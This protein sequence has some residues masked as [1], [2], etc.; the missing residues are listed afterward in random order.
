MQEYK[1]MRIT[2]LIIFSLLFTGNTCF[3]QINICKD[4]I[5]LQAQNE[6]NGKWEVVSGSGTFTSSATAKTIVKD[7][8]IGENVFQWSYGSRYY[9]KTE[10][11]KIIRHQ[12]YANKQYLC[13]GKLSLKAHS[14]NDKEH[15][16]EWTIVDGDATLDELLTNHTVALLKPGKNTF[17]W[18]AFE[19]E[20]STLLSYTYNIDHGTIEGEDKRIICSDSTVLKVTKPEN[21]TGQWK[22]IAGKGTIHT[23]EASETLVTDIAEGKNLFQWKANDNICNEHPEIM[24]INNSIEVDAGYDK[25]LESSYIHLNASPLKEGMKGQWE[26]ISGSCIFLDTIAPITTAFRFERGKN[27]LRW[28]AYYGGCS[29]HDEMTVTYTNLL[30]QTENDRIDICSDSTFIVAEKPTRG[31]GFWKIVSGKAL[32][33]DPENPRTKLYNIQKGEVELMWNVTSG[34]FTKSTRLTVYNH[35]FEVNAGQDQAVVDDR[36]TLKGF[37][38]HYLKTSGEWSVVSGSGTFNTK[39]QNSTIVT[40]LSDGH[41]VFKWTVNANFEQYQYYYFRE[42]YCAASDLVSVYKLPNIKSPSFV[43]PVQKACSPFRLKCL[44][45][46]PE[47]EDLEYSWILDNGIS[48]KQRDLDHEFYL[49]GD[50]EKQI[51]ITLRATS[52]EGKIIE[53]QKSFVLY[54]NPTVSIETEPITTEEQNHNYQFTTNIDNASLYFWKFGDGTTDFSAA[55][56]HEY[57][58]EGVFSVSLKVKNKF[59][60][61]S[62]MRKDNYIEVEFQTNNN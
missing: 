42:G 44:N 55:P 61:E 19:G 53:T 22:L 46:S 11:F 51:K 8:G 26:V 29:A 15:V 14:V 6:G 59:G 25:F 27:T 30:V 31:K 62:N 34:G 32:L 13:N 39:N 1:T 10:Q 37:A 24:I 23:P 45:T 28:N 43:L 47:R 54:P 4:H 17:R 41:N 12:L 56:T 18:Q 16:G 7:I 33:E 52:K 21:L 50:Q 20:C 48:I 58:R 40:N 57:K 3:S 2:F 49:E 9:Q 35:Q 60:C 5:E 36:T 38:D